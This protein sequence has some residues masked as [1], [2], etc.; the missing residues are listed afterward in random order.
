MHSTPSNRSWVQGNLDI[1]R[2]S[3]TF[4]RHHSC[5]S[6]GTRVRTHHV[7]DLREGDLQGDVQ[8]AVRVPYRPQGAGIILHQIFQEL[9]GVAA[10]RRVNH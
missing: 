6:K 1:V 4:A 9:L 2:A 5:C 8:S 10:L 3:T 7:F